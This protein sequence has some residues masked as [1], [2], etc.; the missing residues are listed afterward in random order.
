MII[1]NKNLQQIK[2]SYRPAF[3][4]I[5]ASVCMFLFL[6]APVFSF[7]QKE[8]LS[9]RS[10]KAKKCFYNAT[11]A[12]DVNDIPKAI[13]EL[14][15]AIGADDKFIEAYTLL[16]D[17]YSYIEDPGNAADAYK[18][19]VT[20]NPSYFPNTMLYLGNAEVDAARYDEAKKHLLQF[21]DF[22]NTT[23]E[24]QATAKRLIDDCDFAIEAIKHPVPFSPV[25]AGE[26]IN[27]AEEEYFPSMTVDDSLFLFT[28][29]IHD[30]EAPMGMQE[31][32][33]MSIKKNGVWQ[34]A[35]NIGPPINTPL[36]EGAPS[37]SADGKLIFFTACDRPEGKGSCDIY[38]SRRIGNTWTPPINL[39]SP[40]N[41]GAW[42][43]QPSFSSD[44]KTLYFVRGGGMRTHGADQDIYMTQVSETGWSEPVKL[45]SNINTPRKEESVFIHPDNQTLYFT[46]DGHPGMGGTDIF[47]SRRKPDGT[48]GDP[49]NLGYPI[50]TSKDETGLIV[51][52]K[53]DIAYFSSKRDGG[54]GGL[55]IYSFNL[56][57]AVKPNAVTFVKGKVTDADSQRPLEAK[58]EII[59]VITGK[60]H[61]RILF[62]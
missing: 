38:Y 48:W 44:G 57:D 40:V 12:Y 53:G 41:T 19:A 35:F 22:K 43:S 1:S 13:S 56:Y 14:K 17:I 31:E 9:T 42:E 62:R 26:N 37:F 3:P 46:S 52:P 60:N 28:R 10:S 16:G 24:K 29:R 18:K 36:N 27:T 7:S 32:F 11:K 20:I 21:L 45:P 39:G 49:V 5:F 55:D 61:C 23:S 15:D 8:E 59:D 58:F 6:L 25:N 50:N 2:T 47:V 54:Y 33:F 30:A 51:N 34:K 4:V